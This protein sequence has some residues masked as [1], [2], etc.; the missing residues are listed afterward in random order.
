MV[1]KAICIYSEYIF[2][3]IIKTKQINIYIPHASIVFSFLLFDLKIIQ[4]KK[5]NE[6]IIFYIFF[7]NK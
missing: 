1:I 5:S 4:F 3:T 2:N 7:F 6:T